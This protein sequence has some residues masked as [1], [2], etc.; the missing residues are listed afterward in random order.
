MKEINITVDV[1][2]LVDIS[3]DTQKEVLINTNIQEEEEKMQNFLDRMDENDDVQNVW[4][5]ADM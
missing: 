1:Q 3:T 5:N 4:H 2:P